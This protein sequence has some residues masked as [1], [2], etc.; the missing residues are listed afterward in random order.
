[1]FDTNLFGLIAVTQAFL[2]LLSPPRPAPA[3]VTPDSHLQ[4]D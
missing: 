4:A 1:M 2:P 3:V